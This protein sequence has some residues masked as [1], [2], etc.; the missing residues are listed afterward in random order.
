M[1]I[2]RRQFL[3]GAAATGIGLALPL[4]FGVRSAHAFAQS[5]NLLKFIQPLRGIGGSGIPVAQPDT[6][7]Q[8]WWQPGVTHYTID[9]GGF[10]DQLHPNLPGPTA[11]W[12]FGQKNYH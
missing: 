12:G 2:T 11:L 4:K 1:K 3:K 8:L 9:I 5:Q 7:P 10:V 6:V